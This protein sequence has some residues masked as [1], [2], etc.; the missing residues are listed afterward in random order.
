MYYLA[1]HPDVQAK[2]AEESQRVLGDR[3]PTDADLQNLV[4]CKQ[5]VMEAM[6]LGNAVPFLDRLTTE[7]CMLDGLHIPKGVVV[8]VNFHG[9]HVHP[10]YWKNP[11]EF[12]PERFNKE[13]EHHPFAFVPFSAAERYERC[14]T[15]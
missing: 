14:I 9:A 10:S 12:I 5:V 7:D 13:L 8:Q 2:V 11:K 1:K 4:Y 15:N 6:R 3:D